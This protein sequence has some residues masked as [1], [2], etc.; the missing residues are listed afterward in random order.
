[1][2][3]YAKK[4]DKVVF[5]SAAD[6]QISWGGCDDPR[7]ILNNGE[8]YEVE[9]TDVHSWHTKVKLVGIDGLFNSSHF[10]DAK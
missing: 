1:M 4:G 9:S 3:I 7:P 10:D 5:V 6:S 8:T 2:N